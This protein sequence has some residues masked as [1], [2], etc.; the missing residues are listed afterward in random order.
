MDFSKLTFSSNRILDDLV[1][2]DDT[3]LT[4]K[5]CKIYIP[6]SLEDAGLLV[7]GEYV[8]TI[9]AFAYVIDDLYYSVCIATGRMML[10]PTVI[11]KVKINDEAHYE[12]F[13]EAGSV[14]VVNKNMVK[15]NTLCYYV[16][17]ELISRGRIPEYFS[18]T[19]SLRLFEQSPYYAGMRVGANKAHVEFV[20]A[21]IA[22]DQD[23]KMVYY[24]E[25][26]NNLSDIQKR[27]PAY[28]PFVSVMYNATNTMSR[29]G[30]GYFMDEGLTTS[31]VNKTE[32][33]EPI[34]DLLRR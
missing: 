22:R 17:D 13:F 30:G 6:C 4:K 23:D 9:G 8:Q 5:G 25:T 20:A 10:S 26:L 28:V 1:M 34:E 14:V 11:G 24:R 18:Y 7:M 33:L 16:Y 31:L 15:D 29:L 19:H 12:L 3:F 21:C 2:L 32:R 27:P